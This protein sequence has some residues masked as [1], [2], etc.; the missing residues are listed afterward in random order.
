[1]SCFL[2]TIVFSLPFTSD[3]GCDPTIKE[4]DDCDLLTVMKKDAKYKQIPQ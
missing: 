3:Y 4:L 2:L 1:M